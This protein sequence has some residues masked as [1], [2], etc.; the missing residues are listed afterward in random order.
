M[1]SVICTLYMFILT[2]DIIPYGGHCNLLKCFTDQPV[3]IFGEI[4]KKKGKNKKGIN[5]D[6]V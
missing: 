4:D 2:A 6:F 1:K 5:C 3:P